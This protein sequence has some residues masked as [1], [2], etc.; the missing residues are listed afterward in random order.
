[1]VYGHGVAWGL[2]R[3]CGAP[4][5]GVWL[6]GGESGGVCIELMVGRPWAFCPLRVDLWFRAM[7]I[8]QQAG[9]MSRSGVTP[10]P[11]FAQPWTVVRPRVTL[12]S[13]FAPFGSR[14][15][16]VE[17]VC[18]DQGGCPLGSPRWISRHGNVATRG[19]PEAP[20]E[21]S[22]DTHGHI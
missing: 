4:G 16:N 17:T 3:G 8:S 13:R 9:T 2:G 21:R 10:E 20:G 22:A 18:R 6:G 12:G 14:H 15:W 5:V 19:S 7:L 11:R 1:M